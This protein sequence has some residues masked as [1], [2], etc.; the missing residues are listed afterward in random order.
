[1]KML[2]FEDGDDCWLH[3]GTGGLVR[4]RVLMR[5]N[6]PGYLHEHY[7]IEVQTGV[8]PILEVRDGFQLSDSR[9]E[10][11]GIWRQDNEQQQLRQDKK[12]GWWPRLFGY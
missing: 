4:G 3:I 7:I 12:R 6:L 2:F 11:I 8:D 10:P 5:V 9:D 1:M